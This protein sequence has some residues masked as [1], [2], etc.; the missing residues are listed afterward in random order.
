MP[1]RQGA[2][3]AKGNGL[4]GETSELADGPR[5]QVLHS[6]V[7]GSEHRMLG[8][9]GTQRGRWVIMAVKV[10]LGSGLGFGPRKKSDGHR[11]TTSHT[12]T[13]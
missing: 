4:S 7:K 8:D 10:F 1:N 2:K 3:N 13:G 5:N 6:S 12:L 11:G 9:P